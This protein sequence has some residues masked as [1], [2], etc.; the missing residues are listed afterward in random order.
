MR[1]FE[2]DLKWR[3]FSLFRI[4]GHQNRMPMEY[5]QK[6]PFIATLTFLAPKI[7]CPLTFLATQ[8]PLLFGMHFFGGDL[9]GNKKHQKMEGLFSLAFIAHSSPTYFSCHEIPFSVWDA[10][11]GAADSGKNKNGN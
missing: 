5:P 2:G 4:A 8:L 10:F 11:F 6:I 9:R 1:F 7:G 3:D